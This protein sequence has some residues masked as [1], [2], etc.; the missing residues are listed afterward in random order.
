MEV[1]DTFKYPIIN[2]T[3]VLR[4]L[5]VRGSGKFKNIHALFLIL[6]NVATIQLKQWCQTLEKSLL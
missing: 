4:V 5:N 3:S 2:I 1:P 6:L